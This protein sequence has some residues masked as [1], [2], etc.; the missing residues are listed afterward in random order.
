MERCE[1]SDAA[2]A[3]G[4]GGERAYERRPM[5][6]EGT[7][8]IGLR[9]GGE[10]ERIAERCE[11]DTQRR[12]AA[13]ESDPISLLSEVEVE[14]VVGS[15][16]L[17]ARTDVERDGHLCLLPALP[18]QAF[19]GDSIRRESGNESRSDTVEQHRIPG[20]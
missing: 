16:L 12:M 20:S 14:A 4:A 7:Q 2:R 5:L 13:S 18:M 19:K 17:Q 9:H 8:D 1:V 6:V 10:K 3:A 11:P 15:R